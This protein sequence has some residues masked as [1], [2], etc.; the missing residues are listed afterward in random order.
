MS[1]KRFLELVEITEK[2]AQEQQKYHEELEQVME[3]LEIG[4]FIQEP[5]TMVVHQIVRPAGRYVHFKTID[6]IRTKKEG[7]QAGSL[8]MKKAEEAGFALLKK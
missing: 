8:S 3:K 5:S 4:T 2:L 1:K 7:E 6:Y